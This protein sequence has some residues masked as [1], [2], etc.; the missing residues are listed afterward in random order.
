MFKHTLKCPQQQESYP[1]QNSVE[2]DTLI[3]KNTVADRKIKRRMGW[4][5]SCGNALSS[6]IEACKCPSAKSAL[7]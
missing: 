3:G 5:C 7:S 4:H 6:R 2:K 1:W